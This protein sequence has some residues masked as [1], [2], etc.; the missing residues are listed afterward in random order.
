MEFIAPGFTEVQKTDLVRLTRIVLPARIFHF[1]GG[2]LAA[3]LQAKDR[4]VLPALAPIV[5]TGSIVTVGLLGWSSMGADAFAWGVLVGSILGPFG[6][7]LLGNLRAGIQWPSSTSKR[8]LPIRHLAVA[9]S[10]AGSSVVV[11]DDWMS[12]DS[13]P[14]KKE[15]ANSSTPKLDEGSNGR[16]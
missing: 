12:A 9:P 1:Q 6:L 11:V 15:R 16:V 4:H 8:R 14:C 7:P 2:L 3:T 5:Y 10:D 13:A